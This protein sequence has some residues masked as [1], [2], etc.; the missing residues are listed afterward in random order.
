MAKSTQTFK[1]APETYQG[2][3]TFGGATPPTVDIPS[4]SL[5]DMMPG[6][7]ES[8][9]GGF[10]WNEAAPF[11][12]TG[13]MYDRETSWD[14][15]KVFGKGADALSEYS[16]KWQYDPTAGVFAG[17]D[18]LTNIFE[19][20][21]VD[22]PWAGLAF[23]G[24]YSGEPLWEDSVKTAMTNY[25]GAIEE[26]FDTYYGGLTGGQF[27]SE[28]V[29]DATGPGTW[30]PDP[31]TYDWEG[32]NTPIRGQGE[33]GEHYKQW[34]KYSDITAA[35]YDQTG[36]TGDETP[37]V[38][39]Q[40]QA[41]T[42]SAP[43]SPG[44]KV[45]AYFENRQQAVTPFFGS[46]TGA[47]AGWDP[48]DPYNIAPMID[49]D[50]TLTELTIDS[51][52]AQFTAA[53]Q[54]YSPG[55]AMA[56]HIESMEGT[57]SRRDA[58]QIAIDIKQQDIL[59]QRAGLGQWGIDSDP[60]S[61]TYGEFV[62]ED[63]NIVTGSAREGEQWEAF[64]GGQKEFAPI[65]SGKYAGL[66][67]GQETILKG[68]FGEGDYVTP[69]LGS[70]LA[71]A[72]EN[73]STV[74]ENFYVNP[75]FGENALS[76]AIAKTS[77]DDNAA[78][79]A[80][81][82]A[83]EGASKS[84]FGVGDYNKS[85][86]I[87]AGFMDDDYNLLFDATAGSATENNALENESELAY[88][89][90]KMLGGENEEGAI[91]TYQ[92]TYDKY[93]EDKIDNLEQAHEDFQTDFESTASEFA[94]GQVG[95]K[96]KVA[97]Q[98]GLRSGSTARVKEKLEQGI[99]EAYGEDKLTWEEFNEQEKINF[100]NNVE[101]ISNN[102]VAAWELGFGDAGTLDQ[103]EV[104]MDTS[105]GNIFGTYTYTVTDVDGVTT[106]VTEPHTAESILE[107]MQN[108]FVAG[109][110]QTMMI[111]GVSTNII[112]NTKGDYGDAFD[113]HK[114]TKL[115]L[116]GKTD[117]AL[118]SGYSPGPD[119]KFGTADDETFV[120]AGNVAAGKLPSYTSVDTGW[121]T[122]AISKE[123]YAG[124]DLPT[125]VTSDMEAYPTGG[126]FGT[127]LRDWVGTFTGDL[128]AATTTEAGLLTED[129]ITA[130][131]TASPGS[132]TEAVK[133]AGVTEGAFGDVSTD[134]AEELRLYNLGKADLESGA[135]GAFTD[136]ETAIGQEGIMQSELTGI[137]DE[138]GESVYNKFFT[139]ATNIQK[140]F[141]PGS[142][143]EKAKIAAF[144]ADNT[145]AE[146]ATMAEWA[147]M[148]K[149]AGAQSI[150]AQL[151]LL[152]GSVGGAAHNY[153]NFIQ[154]ELNDPS[155]TNVFTKLFAKDWS[156]YDE[157]GVARVVNDPNDNNNE[158]TPIP[159][160]GTIILTAVA[161]AIVCTAQPWIC[162][163][164]SGSDRKLKK[165]IKKTGTYKGLNVYTFSYLW[166]DKK[167]T[168]FMADEVEKVVPEAV[169]KNGNYK[170]VNYFKVLGSL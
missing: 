95:L 124:V 11:G 86:L 98:K 77:D 5:G 13:P 145:D 105:L 12:T 154:E 35:A 85:D 16:S 58:K 128:G 38:Y 10:N 163:L 31:A 121:E 70:P 80:W 66:Y 64:Y 15:E 122:G 53:K 73:I 123:L 27:S 44:D 52:E 94:Q 56:A 164:A 63:G 57:K 142:E 46:E 152:R 116:F 36:G 143:G 167:H 55:S 109:G 135:A 127:G 37:S 161:V 14:P 79:V 144:Q 32:Y 155:P 34:A 115:G 91:G 87:S 93:T 126:I 106:Q 43:D 28:V 141:G 71:T 2:A 146:N 103:Q 107:V 60:E 47:L 113:T 108:G 131:E 170:M 133:Y 6:A 158:G 130:L 84:F 92:N 101:L 33:L 82:T 48:A 42:L 62:D 157:A 120:G 96:D 25:K 134:K 160:I 61:L 90:R 65:E 4:W 24:G 112:T 119:K 149:T 140:T 75:N 83:M 26:I 67:E 104:I 150:P 99:A 8:M 117:P 88:E 22:D 39:H 114:T 148:W 59:D 23:K 97:K 132:A 89:L 110:T 139:G 17:G 40:L 29:G 18:Y 136:L 151:E 78:A 169:I 7:F 147:K 72:R 9:V 138:P 51:T 19:E 159:P 41:G 20:G 81:N 102:L 3:T 45:K 50:G 30:L 137:E 21:M 76:T 156:L 68:L 74:A 166:D 69:D 153:V 162:A 100:D 54:K 111:D 129:E 125:A 168:G 49:V 118:L 165:N 1:V